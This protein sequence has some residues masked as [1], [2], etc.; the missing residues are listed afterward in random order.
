MP[1]AKRLQTLAFAY[2]HHL[3]TVFCVVA[4]MTAPFLYGKIPVLLDMNLW[5]GAVTVTA[6]GVIMWYIW[7]VHINC[8]FF[9]LCLLDHKI[10]NDI[11]KDRMHFEADC[12][13]D[14]AQVPSYW[15][16]GPLR[17]LT[18]LT[19]PLADIFL[20]IVPTIHSHTKMF[21][22]GGSSHDIPAAKKGDRAIPGSA[23]QKAGGDGGGGGGGAAASAAEAEAVYVKDQN[24]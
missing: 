11:L 8:H 20:Y 16:N 9:F 22:T 23:A 19:F 10:R 3:F 7:M 24:V 21:I 15:C 12:T 17:W 1:L 4:L 6:M 2:D 5:T 14:K 18:L 13:S